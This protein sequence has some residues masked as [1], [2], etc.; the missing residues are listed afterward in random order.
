M[1]DFNYK[2]DD[3]GDIVN[4]RGE[5]IENPSVLFDTVTGTLH[6]HGSENHVRAVYERFRAGG[7]AD[8]MATFHWNTQNGH[9]ANAVEEL[10]KFVNISGYGR[11]F[12]QT[13]IL[14]EDF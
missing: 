2:I 12:Y 7:F 8:G 9:K 4:S 10:N 13:Q 3:Y 1:Q 5:A 6:A 11:R 14:C